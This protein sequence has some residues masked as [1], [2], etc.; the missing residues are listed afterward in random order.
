GGGR[1]GGPRGERRT[2]PGESPRGGGGRWEP[3]FCRRVTARGHRTFDGRSPTLARRT[4]RAYTVEG[5]RG[6]GRPRTDRRWT[7]RRAGSRTAPA[8]RD[9]KARALREEN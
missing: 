5:A 4:P 2:G 9:E 7:G 3:P 8:H 1:P 6:R